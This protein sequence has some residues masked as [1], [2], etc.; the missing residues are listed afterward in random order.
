MLYT[1]FF[2]AGLIAGFICCWA[3]VRQFLTPLK[4]SLEAAGYKVGED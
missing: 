4:D 3:A 1:F 2:F